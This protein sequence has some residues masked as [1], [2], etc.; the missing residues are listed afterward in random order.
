MSNGTP[1][2]QADSVTAASDTAASTHA[3]RRCAAAKPGTAAG[4]GP[5]VQRTICTPSRLRTPAAPNDI[6]QTGKR[7][8]GWIP[9]RSSTPGSLSLQRVGELREPVREHLQDEL[10]QVRR[11]PERS[12]RLRS[13]QRIGGRLEVEATEVRERGKRCRKRR[14]HLGSVDREGLQPRER[15]KVRDRIRHPLPADSHR[16]PAG[17]RSSRPAGGSTAAGRCRT[18]GRPP[19]APAPACR[20]AARGARGWWAASRSRVR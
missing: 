17:R 19:A 7:Q 6:G 9:P 14:V 8:P 12:Q 11:V 1:D 2:A 3:T 4:N 5:L 15:R 10:L 20:R 18:S 13:R 16:E